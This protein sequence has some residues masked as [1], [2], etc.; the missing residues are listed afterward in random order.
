[1]IKN[2]NVLTNIKNNLVV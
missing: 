1:V 2:F